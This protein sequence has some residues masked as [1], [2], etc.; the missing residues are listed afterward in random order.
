MDTSPFT[1]SETPEA[2][3]LPLL[4]LCIMER[5]RRIDKPRCLDVFSTTKTL[6]MLLGS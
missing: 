6:G 5:P 4:K 3:P 1:W 2:S